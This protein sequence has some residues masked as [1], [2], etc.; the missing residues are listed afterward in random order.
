MKCPPAPKNCLGLG[1]LIALQV[2]ELVKKRMPGVEVVGFEKRVS[3][4]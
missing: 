3:W 2:D 4:K 1:A